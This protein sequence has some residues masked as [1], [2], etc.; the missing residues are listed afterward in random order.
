MKKIYAKNPI[1]VAEMI[2]DNPAPKNKVKK[3]PRRVAAGNKSWKTRQR[4]TKNKTKPRMNTEK[5]AST[6]KKMILKTGLAA[7]G[8]IGGVRVTQIL[9]D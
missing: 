1:E 4:K 7:V 2:I 8:T 9:L 3:D 6:G 5:Y